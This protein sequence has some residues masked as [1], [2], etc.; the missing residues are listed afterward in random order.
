MSFDVGD[1]VVYPHHG[2]AIIERREKRNVFGENREYL[3]LKLAYGDLTLMLTKARQILVSELTFAINVTEEEAEQR[4]D[5][6][7]P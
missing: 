2:A 5:D 4:L 1:K 3:V 6:A 7:L